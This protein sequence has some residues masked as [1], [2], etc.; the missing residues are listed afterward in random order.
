MDEVGFIITGYQDGFLRFDT[1]GKFDARI[2]PGQAVCILTKKPIKGHISCL[3]PHTLTD[4]DK[5]KSISTDSL[6]IDAGLSP[7]TAADIVPI[8]TPCVQDID[9]TQLTNG[10]VTGK[11][12]DNRAGMTALLYAMEKLRESKLKINVVFCAGIGEETNGHGA[13]MVAAGLNPTWCVVVD[14][15]YGA[16]EQA[17][18]HKTFPLCS[19]TA[20]GAGP[21]MH[22]KLSELIKRVACK[23]EL[24]HTIEVMTG[25]TSTNAWPIQIANE[26]I[27]TAVLSVPLR[28]MHTPVETA[29][30][31]DIETTGKL[32]ALT[33]EALSEE[34]NKWI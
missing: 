9:L 7:E 20:I 15:T 29:A 34:A 13:K 8:G 1:L 22:Q 26:G 16:Q 18:P 30:V 28:S 14:V 17:Q 2:L 10:K 25:N 21:N 6:Y 11:A 4:D 24:P 23:N 27:P 33:A 12:L 5:R 31:S 3:P 32:L 19:G